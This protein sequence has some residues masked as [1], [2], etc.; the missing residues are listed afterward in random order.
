[1]TRWRPI[2]GF[3]GYDVSDTGEIRNARTLAPLALQSSDSGYLKARVRVGG[4][5]RSL[6]AHRAVLFAFRGPPPTRARRFAAHCNGDKLD[7]RLENLAWKT[8]RE[9]EADK[10]EHGTAPRAFT[11]RKL[12]DD[13]V[14]AIRREVAAGR[15]FS[16][17][18]RERGLHRYS[19]S[20]I[21]RRGAA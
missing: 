12:A 16:A 19:V 8:R 2:L 6:L 17:V 1:M 15:S 14:D 10:L 5:L 18:A 21:A 13:E 9:N 3:P 11:G 7:N 20:R 4:R